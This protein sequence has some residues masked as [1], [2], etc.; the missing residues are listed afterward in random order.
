MPRPLTPRQI[1]VLRWI[2]DGCPPGCWDDNTH[3]TSARALAARGLAIV[4]R[5]KS[6]SG[7]WT[8]ALTDA[9]RHYLTHGDYPTSWPVA[10]SV[11]S[12]PGHTPGEAQRTLRSAIRRALPQR[13]PLSRQRRAIQRQATLLAP[14][15]RGIPMRYTIVVSRVQTA[16]RTVRAANEEDARKK[17]ED[18]LAKP[19]GFLGAWQTVGQDLDIVAVESPLGET[20]LPD[21][22]ALKEDRG[23]ALSIKATARF[24]GLSESSV[25][26]LVNRGDMKHLRVGNRMYVTRDHINE[27]LTTHTH[28]GYSGRWAT[29]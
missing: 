4:G 14:L 29:R 16:T 22:L 1:D 7:A 12:A 5:P 19:Y 17:I 11:S 6:S 23:F 15:I 9:G 26:E 8:A 28:A 10:Q 20:P 24:L 18:E 3:K 21:H 2:S 25:R 13:T 27:F